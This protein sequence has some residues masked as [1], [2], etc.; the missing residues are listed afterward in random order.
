M[1]RNTQLK[2]RFELTRLQTE[3]ICS[4]LEIEDYVPQPIV[5]VSPPKWHLGHTTWFFEAFILKDYLEGYKVFDEGYSYLFN[6]YY[7]NAGKRVERHNR[8]FMSRPL[9]REVMEYRQYVTQKCVELLESS[10]PKN[11]LDI[12][13]IGINHEQQHQEL[14]VYDIKYILGMQPLLPI[15]GNGFSTSEE[16]SE[17]F[18][19]FKAGLYEIG[20]ETKGFSYDNELGKHQVYLQE[21][22]IAKKLVSNGEYLEFMKAGGYRDFDLWL[23]EGWDFVQRERLEAPLYWHQRGKDWYNY[24]LKGLEKVDLSLPLQHV[25]FYEAQAFATWKGMRLPTEYEWEVASGR[26]NWG[27]LWEWTNSAYLP[28]P[29]YRKMPGALGE[30]NGKF[31]SNQYVLRGGSV[32]TP[33]GHSRMTYRNFFHATSRWLFSGIRLI[34]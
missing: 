19:P 29:G 1:K 23:S 28:Y 34:K 4:P 22:E 24:S 13:E 3:R 31:M 15:Y 11:V 18:A 32:A 2:I 8:G 20:A 5:D 14:L 21:F 17:G 6:S 25:S 33:Y 16:L 27:Q 10:P 30:Y 12:V 26:L 9:V 7:N